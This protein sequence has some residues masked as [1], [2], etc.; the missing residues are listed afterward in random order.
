MWRR[1]EC[2]RLGDPAAW[3]SSALINK[4]IHDYI[5]ERLQEGL[6]YSRL[7]EM[8]MNT[9]SIMDI[10]NKYGVAVLKDSDKL[11]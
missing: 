8:E 6:R 10:D 5:C 2:E 7:S 4:H 9:D 11:T 1:D 3:P